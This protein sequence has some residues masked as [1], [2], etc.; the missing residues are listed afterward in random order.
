M[1]GKRILVTG[2]AGFVGTNLIKKLENDNKIISVDNYSTGK[3]SNEIDSVNVNYYNR[4]ITKDVDVFFHNDFDVIF[5][6][7]AIARIQPSFERP[8][9]YFEHNAKGTMVIANEALKKNIPVIFAGSSSHHSGKYKNPYTFSKDISEEIM[10]MYR[11]VYGLKSSTA[12]FYNVYGPNQIEDGSYSTV[13]GRWINLIK[14][15]EPITIYGDGS[16]R[17]DFTHVDDIVDGLIAIY[18]KEAWDYT[19]EF[20]TGK[21]Y[22]IQEVADMFEYPYIDYYPDKPGE[23]QVTLCTSEFERERLSWEPK[24]NLKNYIK[25]WIEENK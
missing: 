17:R 7:A 23:A 5:H 22:S 21:N 3:H 8:V 9:D 20:G 10:T 2:G 12:R 15:N 14:Q 16:K 13:I 4:D 25:N 19:F 18:D 1:Q 6:L 11:K 24:R